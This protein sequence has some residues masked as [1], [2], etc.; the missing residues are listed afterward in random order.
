MNVYYT[1]T[2]TDSLSLLKSA[3]CLEGIAFD[4]RLLARTEAGKPYFGD[5]HLP[6][7]NLTHTQ[8]F[9]AVAVGNA[10][11]GIDA[12]VR[13]PRKTDAIRRRLTDEERREDFF[14]LWTAKEAYIKLRGTTLASA[15]P[16]LVY[17]D[18]KLYEHGAPIDVFLYQTEIQTCCIS[19]C[20]EQEEPIRFIDLSQ[21]RV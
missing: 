14:R 18:G 10:E 20:S 21:T 8:N 6:R 2:P 3:M 9:C 7:F 1:F 16:S 17:R 4:E 11:V 5:P 15:L 12:E 13:I 19:I